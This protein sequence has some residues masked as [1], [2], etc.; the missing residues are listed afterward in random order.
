MDSPEQAQDTPQDSQ[1]PQDAQN[2]T[3]AQLRREILQEEEKARQKRMAYLGSLDPNL[4][5]MVEQWKNDFQRVESIHI[6]DQ[7]Y[8]YRGL[9]RAEFYAIMGNTNDPLKQDENFASKGL[10]WPQIEALNWTTRAAGIPST[11]SR[12]IQEASGFSPADV[13]PV[14]L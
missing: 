3:E 12:L 13:A 7:L 10:L 6:L 4:P 11:L 9:S 8:I 2:K 5:A 14:R 1:D